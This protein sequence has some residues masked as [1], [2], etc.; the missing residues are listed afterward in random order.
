M[1]NVSTS[2][3][4][5]PR[6]PPEASLQPKCQRGH[7]ETWGQAVLR[8]LSEGFCPGAGGTALRKDRDVSVSLQAVRMGVGMDRRR[9]C[10]F[11][12]GLRMG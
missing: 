1:P 10:S 12:H 5:A 3:L 2:E 4:V 8:S 6:I 7:P 11:C 9:S